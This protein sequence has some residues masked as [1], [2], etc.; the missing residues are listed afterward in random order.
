LVHVDEQ[1]A[2]EAVE[3]LREIVAWP[4]EAVTVSRDVTVEQA[5]RASEAAGGDCLLI[6]ATPT[7]WVEAGRNLLAAGFFPVACQLELG[8][9]LE[10]GTGGDLEFPCRLA[11]RGDAERLMT[12][13]LERWRR[14]PLLLD[15]KAPL[16]DD[17]GMDTWLGTTPPAR[18]RIYLAEN[19]GSVTWVAVAER[20]ER[21][22]C[23]DWGATGEKAESR[24]EDLIGCILARGRERGFERAEM[25][26]TVDRGDDVNRAAALGFRV[27]RS[28]ML[29]RRVH[30]VTSANGSSP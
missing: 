29:Y 8:L 21:L 27:W 30:R 2:F 19:G 28:W 4:V 25:H 7:H 24:L 12:T 6:A 15:A 5:Q 26:L 3:R 14:D 22:V 11:R 20:A 17:L 9:S 16:K 13:W 1:A 10:S 23:E 18:R